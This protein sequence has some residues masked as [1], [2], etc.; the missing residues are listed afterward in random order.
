MARN[1]EFGNHQHIENLSHEIMKFMKM[2]KK[3]DIRS[4]LVVAKKQNLE[5][6]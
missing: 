5:I 2:E 1:M 6:S 3:W 4:S